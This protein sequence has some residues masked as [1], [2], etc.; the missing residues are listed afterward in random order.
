MV[1]FFLIEAVFS[2]QFICNLLQLWFGLN[3]N[4]NIILDRPNMKFAREKEFKN[5]VCVND[6]RNFVVQR[7]KK[8][9]QIFLHYENLD[10]CEISKFKDWAKELGLS[11][12]EAPNSTEA[13]QIPGAPSDL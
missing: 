3:H 1:L 2:K 4:V 7:K 8:W 9:D 12:P 5:C 13:E 10:L 6:L 11:R